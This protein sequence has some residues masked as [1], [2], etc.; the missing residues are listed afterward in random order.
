MD[1]PALRIDSHAHVFPWQSPRHVRQRYTPR[2]PARLDDYVALLDAFELTN[3]VLVQPSFLGTDNSHL[4]ECLA[5]APT[6]LRG[7]VVVGPDVT[8]R[9]LAE[10]NDLGVVGIRLNMLDASPERYRAADWQAVFEKVAALGWVIDIQAHGAD[11]PSALNCLWTCRAAL[12]VDHFGRPDPNLGVNDAGFKA[13]VRLAEH[14]RIWVKLS[15]PY[16]ISDDILEKHAVRLVDLFG[17]ERL[18]W[19][20]DWPWTQHEDGMDFASSFGWLEDWVPDAAFR[21]QILGRTAAELFKFV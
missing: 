5:A 21:D 17:P 7:I 6:R 13:L 19:G 16:R 12:V 11:L 3:G 18:L 2:G 15:A 8:D 14:G 4:I 9:T 20:S 1:L 10:F